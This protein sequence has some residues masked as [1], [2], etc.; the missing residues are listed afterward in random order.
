MTPYLA[1]LL[2]E[3]KRRN[4]TRPDKRTLEQMKVRGEKWSPAPWIFPSPTSADEKI[5]GPRIVHV[6]A[7]E[8][9]GIPH[10]TLHG[11]RRSFCTLSEWCEA[12]VAVV[13]QIQCA[14]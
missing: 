1:T 8:A 6:R 10:I 11:L 2:L 3:L 4:E 13:A 12:P 9:A 7:L 5:A 14:L